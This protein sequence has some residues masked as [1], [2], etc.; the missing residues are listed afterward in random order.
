MEHVTERLEAEWEARADFKGWS[1][2][3]RRI[4]TTYVVVEV[5][6]L[7]AKKGN[8]IRKSFI[9]TGIAVAPDGS[10]DHL[11]NIKCLQEGNIRPDFTGWETVTTI[12][13][14]EEYVTR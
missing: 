14:L 12:H 11:I 10:E 2:S 6:R 3:T 4:L 1:L 8:L 9:N 7:L 5:M 13:A